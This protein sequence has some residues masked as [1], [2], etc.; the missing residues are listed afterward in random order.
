M[1]YKQSSV[2][3]SRWQR[4]TRKEGNSSSVASAG[5]ATLQT[6]MN[7]IGTGIAARAANPVN[8][9]ESQKSAP[10]VVNLTRAAAATRLR[11]ANT[12]NG[13][14][15]VYSVGVVGCVD[16]GAGWTSLVTSAP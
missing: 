1:E 11:S 4:T 9:N 15:V 7:S 14:A 10:T 13:E 2:I 6:I 8:R 3:F 5:V 12:I 16:T